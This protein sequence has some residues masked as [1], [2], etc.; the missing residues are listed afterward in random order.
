MGK[1]ADNLSCRARAGPRCA[2]AASARDCTDA[3]S[4]V[5][6][7]CRDVPRHRREGGTT[8]C[9][10][11]T[12]HYLLRNNDAHCLVS[13]YRLPHSLI[14][15]PFYSPLSPHLYW[16]LITSYFSLLTTTYCPSLTA[17]TYCLYLLFIVY[18]LPLTTHYLMLIAHCSLPTSYYPLLTAHCLLLTAHFLL[19]TASSSLL[20]T[21]FSLLTTHY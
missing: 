16:L 8:H 4:G 10:L 17:T 3:G 6:R 21:Y 5:G 11:R 1:H 7:V 18:C 19:L 20:N 2:G 15:T 14:S 9:L 13:N 12:A